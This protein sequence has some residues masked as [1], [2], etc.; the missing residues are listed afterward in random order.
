[1][2]VSRHQTVN[3]CLFGLD[4]RRHLYL[5]IIGKRVRRNRDR[6]SIPH[7][8]LKPGHYTID[9]SISIAESPH[10]LER[11][12]VSFSFIPGLLAYYIPKTA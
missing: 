8:I 9:L 3:A 10:L 1:M 6:L 2:L 4:R 11:T 12:I 5:C 7:H